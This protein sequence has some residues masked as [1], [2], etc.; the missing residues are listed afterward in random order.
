MDASQNILENPMY[1]L[2]G[3][4]SRKYDIFVN[5]NW[6]DTWWEYYSTHLRTNIT[7]NNTIKENTQNGK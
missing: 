7:Q 5:C 3:V 6:V 2:I 1:I 4:I